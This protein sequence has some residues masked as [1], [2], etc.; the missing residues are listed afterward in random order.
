MHKFSGKVGSNFRV[1]LVREKERESEGEG[2]THFRLFI[3]I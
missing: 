1:V 3:P 2:E